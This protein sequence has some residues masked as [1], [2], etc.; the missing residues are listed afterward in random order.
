[1]PERAFKSYNPKGVE[2][3]LH[4]GLSGLSKEVMD[5]FQEG[6]AAQVANAKRFTYD[7]AYEYL[8]RG[9]GEVL[10]H[11]IYEMMYDIYEGIEDDIMEGAIDTHL[12]IYPDYVPRATNILQLAIDCSKAGYR[13]ICCKDHFFANVG[14]CWAAQSLVEDMVRRE[15]LEHSCQVLG[16]NVLAFSYHPDQ[17]NLI[18]KYPNLGGIFF[19]TMTGGTPG[20]GGPY[21]P[22]IDDKGEL[23]PEV[24]ECIRRMA[25]Y[26]ICVFSGHRTYQEALAMVKYCHEVGGHILLTHAGGGPFPYQAGTIEQSKEL[27]KLGAYIEVALHF[28]VGAA[29]IWPL[30]NPDHTVNWLKEMGPKNI[31][32]STDLGQPTALHPIEGYRVAIRMLAH[33]GISKEDLKIMFQKNAI[34]ALYL[35]ER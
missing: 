10:G 33:A 13:A 11:Y 2:P 25:N 3:D 26:K 23:M 8:K 20:R 17:V 29:A 9:E 16:T 6:R 4:G 7:E 35:D 34:E 18:R 19:P 1:M 31:V 24:K 21:L 27:V 14:Q 28:F 5:K 15:E 12:H 30:S 22:I 32:M